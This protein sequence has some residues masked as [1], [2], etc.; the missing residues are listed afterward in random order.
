MSSKSRL[1]DIASSSFWTLL[2]V[3]NAL[4][5]S[6]VVAGI[7][8]LPA[9]LSLMPARFMWKI[10]GDPASKTPRRQLIEGI[11]ILSVFILLAVAMVVVGSYRIQTGH[12]GGGVLAVGGAL[13]AILFSISMIRMIRK[14]EAS[15]R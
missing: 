13:S 4:H 10:V 1:S 8:I 9:A 6:W 7:C 2:A 3:Y 15:L 5:K 11:V 12:S 14:H